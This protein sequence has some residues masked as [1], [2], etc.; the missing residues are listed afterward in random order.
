VLSKEQDA[1][2]TLVHKKT[3]A[4]YEAENK[5]FRIQEKRE[6]YLQRH[7]INGYPFISAFPARQFLKMKMIRFIPFS[8]I[9]ASNW[10]SLTNNLPF[11]QFVAYAI[12]IIWPKNCVMLVVT[13]NFVKIT[14]WICVWCDRFQ[15]LNHLQKRFWPSYVDFLIKSMNYT[16]NNNIFYN[17]QKM[18]RSRCIAA[19]RL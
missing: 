15:N 19:H 8:T 7:V 2:G 11:D 17:V 6:M 12:N 16:K 9:Y 13:T 10:V 1:V 4:Q 3:F 18:L 5:L 14:A